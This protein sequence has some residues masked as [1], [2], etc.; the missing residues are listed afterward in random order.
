MWLQLQGTRQGGSQAEVEGNLVIKVTAE[1]C[2]RC[3]RVTVRP[4][5]HK[6]QT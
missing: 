3:Q 5:D 1:M 4:V 6:T 2:P